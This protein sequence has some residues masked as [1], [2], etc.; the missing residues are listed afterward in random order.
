VSEDRELGR[1]ASGKL[2]A[3]AMAAAG[4]DESDASPQARKPPEKGRSL[5]WAAQVVEA[6]LKRANSVA[7]DSG[8]DLV[9]G[10]SGGWRSYDAADAVLPKHGDDWRTPGKPTASTMRY[11]KCKAARGHALTLFA[12]L[13]YG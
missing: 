10:L 9:F 2:A 12:G 3:A 13:C 11:Q 5:G 1:S 8:P 6:Q 7:D 4:S